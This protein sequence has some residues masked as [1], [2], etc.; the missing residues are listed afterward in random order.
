MFLAFQ[1]VALVGAVLGLLGAI[2]AKEQEERGMMLVVFI[3]CMG[4]LGA[5]IIFWG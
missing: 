3:V 2:G 4:V 5:T 1:I